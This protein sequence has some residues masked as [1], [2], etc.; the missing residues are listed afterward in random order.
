MK[1]VLDIIHFIFIAVPLYIGVYIGIQLFFL[2][3]FLWTKKK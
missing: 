2:I 3:K 1:K